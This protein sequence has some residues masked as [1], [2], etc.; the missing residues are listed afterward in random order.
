MK[1][2]KSIL[3]VRLTRPVKK[4]ATPTADKKKP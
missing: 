3:G 2:R 1:I 4:P